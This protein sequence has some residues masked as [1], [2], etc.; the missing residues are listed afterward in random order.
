[1]T[2]RFDPFQDAIRWVCRQR[3]VARD[4]GFNDVAAFWQSELDLLRSRVP[5]KPIDVVLS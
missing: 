5:A 3:D 2:K 4:R 1:M